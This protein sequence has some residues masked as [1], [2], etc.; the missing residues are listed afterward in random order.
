MPRSRVAFHR[1]VAH[2]LLWSTKRVESR[3]RAVGWVESVVLFSH[4][5]TAVWVRTGIV[6]VLFGV[7]LLP[8]AFGR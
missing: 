5:F 8:L 2:P 1:L 7:V 6:A 3:Q 4:R